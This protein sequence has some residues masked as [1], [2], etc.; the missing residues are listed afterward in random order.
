[1]SKLLADAQSSAMVGVGAFLEYVG[2][3]RDVGTRE[4]EAHTVSEGAVQVMS[5]HAAKGL[6]FPVVVIGDAGRRAPTPR[7]VLIDPDLGVLPPLQEE[8]FVEDAA[9]RSAVERIDSAVYRLAQRSA[10]DQ[11]EAESDRLLYVAATRAKEMLLISGVAGRSPTGWLK[12]LNEALPLGEWLKEAAT[13]DAESTEAVTEIWEVGGQPVRCT[14]YPEGFDVPSPAV[15]VA[16]LPALLTLPETPPLLGTLPPEPV[17]ADE[18]AE[19]ATRDP[20]RRVWRVVPDRD[21]PTA[22]AWVVGQIVHGALEGWL[23]PDDGPGYERWA[24]SEAQGCGLTDEREIRN[25]LQR[26]RRILTRLQGTTLYS[27][28]VAADERLH[29]V[30]YSIIDGA[31]QLEH[32]VIDAL[33]R[34]EGTWTLVEFK[35]DRVVDEKALEQM[36]DQEDYV[37]QVARYL[38]AV[39]RLL[40]VRPR[41]VLCLLN[42]G[43]TVHLVE[44]R[45]P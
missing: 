22:P 15:A 19:A 12:R 9:G 45:W 14:V 36:L 33:F 21:R 7:G 4:G 29:E 16:P 6:E 17:V 25:A 3:L 20:P 42:Y 13:E 37:P 27:R 40:G 39:E 8:R 32:G 44:D 41:A 10:R 11:G 34:E 31:G 35:T 23:F 24:A 30:P 2:Q 38:A 18:E 1:M 28:M 26:A 5:V 43:R